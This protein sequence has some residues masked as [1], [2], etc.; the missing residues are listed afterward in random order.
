MTTANPSGGSPS[1]F[2]PNT[3]DDQRAM[4]DAIG[5]ADFED[6]ISDVPEA[7]RHPDLD[8]RAAAH[9]MSLASELATLAA[10]NYVP[11]DYACCLGS[12]AYR[13]YVPAVARKVANRGEFMTSYTP[14]QPEVA[15]GSL[16][17][18]FEFQTMV[19]HLMG[20]PVANG[21]RRGRAH[22]GSPHKA[23]QGHRPR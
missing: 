5:V 4:L 22:G 2:I 12:G 10:T 23:R 15:Q 14:Y 18:A 21:V 8:L 20:L 6:L 1:T 9:E 13:H 17:V 3:D 11:G 16:Q 7:H 19:S